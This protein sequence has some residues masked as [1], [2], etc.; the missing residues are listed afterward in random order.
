MKEIEDAIKK[1]FPHLRE[2]ASREIYFYNAALFNQYV[3]FIKA[4]PLFK[5]ELSLTPTTEKKSLK[6]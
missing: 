5:Q 4:H 3:D 1:Q 2:Q 6:L